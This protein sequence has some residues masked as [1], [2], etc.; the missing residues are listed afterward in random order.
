MYDFHDGTADFW[1]FLIF[2]FVFASH[3]E[4]VT[5]EDDDAVCLILRDSLL[6]DGE[7]SNLHPLL[8]AVQL[9]LGFAGVLRSTSP[10]CFHGYNTGC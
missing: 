8:V 6:P 5:H 2:L 3:C 4:L 1:V 9:L 7:F 10:F